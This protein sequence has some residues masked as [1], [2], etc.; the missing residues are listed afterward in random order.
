MKRMQI[1]L[2]KS[3]VLQLHVAV[4]VKV[5]TRLKELKFAALDLVKSLRQE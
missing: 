5:L 4:D 2:E 1:L 3:N